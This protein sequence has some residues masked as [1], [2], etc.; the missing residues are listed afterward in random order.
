MFYNIASLGIGLVAW[1]MGICAVFS[2][3]KQSRYQMASFIC[4]CTS[5]LLQFY[6][7]RRRM[8]IDDWVAVDDTI[9]AICMAAGVLIAVTILLNLICERRK[10]V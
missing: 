1:A 6:E 3:K 5:L 7:I 9:N 8:R 4:C 10:S 2:G